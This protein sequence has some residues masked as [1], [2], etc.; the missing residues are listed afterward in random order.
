MIKVLQVKGF[1][2]LLTK[3]AL[4]PGVIKSAVKLFEEFTYTAAVDYC[5]S[6]F[7]IK[8][9]KKENIEYFRTY[10][11]HWRNLTN[12]QTAPYAIK[13][14]LNDALHLYEFKNRLK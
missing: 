5:Y 13:E 3:S 6:F 11:G 1:R 10:G 7:G 4:P 14:A 2:K 12:G 8:F 9:F